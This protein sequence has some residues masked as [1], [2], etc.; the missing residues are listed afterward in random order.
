M[1]S[2]NVICLHLSG[3][4]M[5]V[6][7]KR[8]PP[9][10]TANFCTNHVKFGPTENKNSGATAVVA[11]NDLV[12]VSW[13]MNCGQP[14]ASAFV[15]PPFG[16]EVLLAD[17]PTQIEVEQFWWVVGEWAREGEGILKSIWRTELLDEDFLTREQREW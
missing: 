12:A 8:A 6:H 4:F 16:Q 7:S 11:A 10:G 14:K 17:V 5:P 15:I 1:G 2:P 3:I 13:E 9:D